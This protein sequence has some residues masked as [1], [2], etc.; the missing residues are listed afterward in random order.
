VKLT[1]T[2]LMAFVNYAI[3]VADFVDFVL[4]RLH[5]YVPST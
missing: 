2:S 4:G 3:Y 5:W 1:T